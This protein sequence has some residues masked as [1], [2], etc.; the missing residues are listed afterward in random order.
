MLTQVQNNVLG[1]CIILASQKIRHNRCKKTCIIAVDKDVT[2]QDI[3]EIETSPSTSRLT[4]SFG[5]LVVRFLS[6]C[7]PKLQ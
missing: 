5:R 6:T 1:C 7:E 3:D 2:L 4:Q